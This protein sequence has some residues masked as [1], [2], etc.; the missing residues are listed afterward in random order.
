MKKKKKI[1]TLLNFYHPSNLFTTFT[2]GWRLKAEHS[3]G[4]LFYKMLTD[5][6]NYT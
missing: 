2:K 6:N 5:T 4:M 3:M 1:Q